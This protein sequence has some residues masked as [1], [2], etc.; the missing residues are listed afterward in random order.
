MQ[1]E[2]DM[3]IWAAHPTPR[4]A[5]AIV[6]LYLPAKDPRVLSYKNILHIQ[7]TCR[8]LQNQ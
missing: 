3:A 6:W 1:T 8:R 5:R 7:D 2:L 4:T